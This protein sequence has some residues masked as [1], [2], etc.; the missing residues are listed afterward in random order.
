MHYETYDTYNI[1]YHSEIMC[2]EKSIWIS[3]KNI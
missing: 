2:D 1:T 3:N